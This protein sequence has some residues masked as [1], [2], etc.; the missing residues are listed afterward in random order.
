MA[1]ESD[2][3]QPAMAYSPLELPQSQPDMQQQER[4]Y[5]YSEYQTRL[6]KCLYLQWVSRKNCDL[7]INTQ[8]FSL[9]VHSC[10]VSCFSTKVYSHMSDSSTDFPEVLN[11]DFNSE[12]LVELVTFMYTGNLRLSCDNAQA[13]LKCAE[14][15]GVTVAVKFVQ[16]YMKKFGLTPATHTGL[17]LR[18]TQGDLDPQNGRRGPLGLP[19]QSHLMAGRSNEPCSPDL[20]AEINSYMKQ[21]IVEIDLSNQQLRVGRNEQISFD[22]INPWCALTDDLEEASGSNRQSEQADQ[23]SEQLER[24]PQPSLENLSAEGNMIEQLRAANSVLDWQNTKAFWPPAQPTDGQTSAASKEAEPPAD[25]NVKEEGQTC[26]NCK[27]SLTEKVPVKR[28][29]KRKRNTAKAAKTD[30]ASGE[31]KEGEGKKKVAKT[32]EY[33]CSLCLC[34]VD[35]KQELSRHNRLVHGAFPCSEC[36]EGF[37]RKESLTRHVRKHHRM[38]AEW[39]CSLCDQSFKKQTKYERHCLEVHGENRPYVCDFEGCNFKTN[40]AKSLNIHKENVH[41]TARNFVCGK[42]GDRFPSRRYLGNHEKNCIHTG[43]HLCS[44]CGAVFNLK[45]TLNH[46][47][48][49]VHLGEIPYSCKVCGKGFTDHR[50]LS[51]H[52]RTHSN[53]LPYTCEYCGKGFQHSNSLKYHVQRVHQQNCP[54]ARRP[55]PAPKQPPTFQQLSSGQPSSMHPERLPFLGMGDSSQSMFGVHPPPVIF[56]SFWRLTDTHL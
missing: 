15:F 56:P 42:C 11:V 9:P 45:H 50:N 4:V 44:E 1:S 41:A 10:V 49:V 32:A 17:D 19:G 6:Q 8:G 27:K 52:M 40:K 31:G 39:K 26:V 35:T 36:N 23:S 55:Q 16:E 5:H 33:T 18:S 7:I 43:Q 25:K 12:A 28:K 38:I 48:R 20:V 46:H 54:Q 13:L 21:D 30:S 2:C 53:A 37:M 14:W 24:K 51:R 47:I 3:L 29:R 34:T 22:S